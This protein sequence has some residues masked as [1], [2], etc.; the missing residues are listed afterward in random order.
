MASGILPPCSLIMRDELLRHGGSAVQHDGETGQTLRDLLENVE[1]QLGL[2]AGLELVRAVAGADG[3]GEAVA[4]GAGHEFLDVLGTGVGAVLRPRRGRRPPRPRAC[5]ARLQRRHRG[6]ARI[7]RPCGC[8]A[9]LSSKDLLLPSIMTEVKPPSMQL[10][11]S[12]KL[13]PWSRCR[14]IGISGIS[15]SAASTSLTR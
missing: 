14:A 8:S 3:D 7:R 10:L 1:A 12:S 5:P 11:Q 4:A 9:M 15:C 2:R 6:R 13:S